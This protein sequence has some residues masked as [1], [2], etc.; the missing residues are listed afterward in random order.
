MHLHM[1]ITQIGG[2]LLHGE[3]TLNARRTGD[4]RAAGGKVQD[5]HH[6]GLGVRDAGLLPHC[7]WYAVLCVYHPFIMRLSCIYHAF[8]Y[9]Y[10]AFIMRLSIMYYACIYHVCVYV[11]ICIYVC[12]YV[13][14]CVRDA[15]LLPHCVWYAVLCVYLSCIRMHM[16]IRKHMRSECRATA[17]LRLVVLYVY[18]CMCSYTYACTY[19][20]AFGMPGY[21]HLAFGM[22]YYTYRLYIYVYVYV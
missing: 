9:Q 5:P 21:C 13:C 3:D 14:I 4:S 12:I 11:C 15:G 10:Y 2:V 1:Y 22:L 6:P 8:I 16:H 18:P 19:T 20:Y 17:A 7:V